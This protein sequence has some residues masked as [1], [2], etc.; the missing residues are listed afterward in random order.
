MYERVTMRNSVADLA[1]LHAVT[2]N[3]RKAALV[4]ALDVPG[5]GLAPPSASAYCD[6]VSVA[7][8]L[9]FLDVPRMEAA[10]HT[11]LAAL[12]RAG[13]LNGLLA[14]IVDSA[15]PPV[16]A[17]KENHLADLH[18]AIFSLS[19]DLRVL[20]VR[21]R[22]S[23]ALVQEFCARA[24]S[25]CS[26][27]A[28]PGTTTIGVYPALYSGHSRARY[29]EDCVFALNV[30]LLR[31]PRTSRFVGLDV[32]VAFHDLSPASEIVQAMAPHLPGLTS[33]R[34]FL[35]PATP[36]PPP[37]D[38]TLLDILDIHAA[39]GPLLDR[40]SSLE[41]QCDHAW[42][43]LTAWADGSEPDFAERLVASGCTALTT[44]R[45]RDREWLSRGL[46]SSTWQ[47]FYIV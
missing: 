9:R 25:A 1:L 37:D 6:V 39:V 44:F 16:G 30:P 5:H 45:Y 18:D 3:A 4:R 47:R 15:D 7:S 33:L 36:N 35:V 13:T 23:F 19:G 20:A 42:R 46:G 11:R 43:A 38:R 27:V 31:D 8:N 28:L 14:L 32:H 40:I 29:L 22:P 10:A 12:M 41:L 26:I 24:S 34:M 2:S 17:L 21:G